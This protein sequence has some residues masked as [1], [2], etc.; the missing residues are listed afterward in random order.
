MN[1]KMK[2]KMV[3]KRENFNL[4]NQ[5]SLSVIHWGKQPESGV[6]QK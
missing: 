6:K 1:T 5:I 3:W 2:M 4:V